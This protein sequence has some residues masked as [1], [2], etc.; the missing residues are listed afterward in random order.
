VQAILPLAKKLGAKVRKI[1]SL[2]N[3]KDL[4]LPIYICLPAN[5][6]I[7]NPFLVFLL[8]YSKSEHQHEAGNKDKARCFKGT[9]REI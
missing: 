6:G 7:L 2:P 8:L 4:K 5:A 9:I 1:S 3:I